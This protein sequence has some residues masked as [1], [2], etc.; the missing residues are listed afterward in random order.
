MIDYPLQI[1]QQVY[2][3]HQSIKWRS[4]RIIDFLLPCY[5]LSG[6]F[7]A[8]QYGTWLVA[9]GVGGVCLLVYYC[10]KIA[11]PDSNL[12][13]YVLSAI[14]GVF[15]IQFNYQMHGLFEMYL[16]AYIGSALLVTYQK[17]K[18]QIPILIVTII[19]YALLNYLQYSGGKQIYVAPHS[20]FDL[21]I[22]VIHIVLTSTVFF[23]CGLLACQLKKYNDLHNSQMVK[24]AALEKEAHSLEEKKQKEESLEERNII[25]ESIGDAFFTTDHNCM[26]TY[27]NK[28]AERILHKR[29]EETLGRYLWALYDDMIGTQFDSYFHKAQKRSEPQHFELWYDMAKSW[30][31]I[32]IYPSAGGA[33]IYVRD[34]TK[35]KMAEIEMNQLHQDLKEHVKELAISNAELEQFAYTASHDLQEPLRMVTGFLAQFEKKYYDIID[36]KG[37]KYIRFALNGGN[38]MRQMIVDLLEFSR[39]GRKEDKLEEVD[40]QH[41]VDEIKAVYKKQMLD[42]SIVIQ[43]EEL[44]KLKTFKAPIR[45]VFQNLISNGIKYQKPGQIPV[46]NIFFKETAD[47]YQFSVNDNG[48]GIEPANFEEIFIVFKRLHDGTRYEGTGMG[49]AITKKIIENLGGRIWIE[50]EKGKGSSFYF[51]MPK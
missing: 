33:S 8:Q 10:I 7:F 3:F 44:P 47:D 49:L 30:F 6:L 45:Q 9:V 22:F 28:S 4:D 35:R 43:S 48:I 36:E 1:K 37:K 17:W 32:S 27:W 11:L 26:V 40:L 51:T 46:I 50:S 14:L 5:F 38:Q 20:H 12:Y 29:K 34:I 24:L 39:A 19:H 21:I 15:T 2:E 25:L 18:L 31:D 42:G 23:I 41:V 16:F 13:Q